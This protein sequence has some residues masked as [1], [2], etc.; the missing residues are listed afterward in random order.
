[1]NGLLVDWRTD[2]DIVP[3]ICDRHDQPVTLS[4]RFGKHRVV[5]VPCIG[6]VNGDQVDISKV[7]A[8]LLGGRRYIG[9]E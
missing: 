2:L 4:G 5:K 3:H 8:V 1:M 7:D 9:A 6:A